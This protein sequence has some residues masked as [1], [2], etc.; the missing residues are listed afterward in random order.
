MP[1]ISGSYEGQF[2]STNVASIGDASTYTTASDNII[3]VTHAASIALQ[4][5]AVCGTSASGDV[6]F[7]ILARVNKDWDEITNPFTSLTLN[8]IVNT[9]AR[10]TILVNCRDVEALKIG[11]IENTATS[12]DNGSLAEVNCKYSIGF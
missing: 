2:Y 10:G 6:L 1:T 7:R 8:Q 3:D 11:S 9:T 5:S 12:T 4:G